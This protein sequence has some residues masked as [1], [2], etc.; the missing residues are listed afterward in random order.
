[1]LSYAPLAV[2]NPR[3]P[4]T[5]LGA[6]N[7]SSCVMNALSYTAALFNQGC[8]WEQNI[9]KSKSRCSSKCLMQ[10]EPNDGCYRK[11]KNTI[12]YF[13]FYLT[14]AASWHSWLAGSHKLHK[15]EYPDAWCY[16]LCS[17]HGMRGSRHIAHD[18]KRDKGRVNSEIS[19]FA[20]V[21]ILCCSSVIWQRFTLLSR[22]DSVILSSTPLI[23]CF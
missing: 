11:G 3:S 2:W 9:S 7:L 10:R 16:D 1:M 12:L 13:P 17:P 20:A 5:L 15:A 19:S 23:Q 4:I 8:H 21:Q 14:Q 22:G 6:V 18:L